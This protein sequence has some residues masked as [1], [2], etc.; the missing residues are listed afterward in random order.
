[1]S[2]FNGTNLGVVANISGNNTFAGSIGF[3][4]AGSG[5]GTGL[6]RVDIFAGSLELDGMLTRYQG[7]GANTVRTIDKR[8]TGDLIIS[9]NN[10]AAIPN[11]SMTT[12]I[13]D[14]QMQVNE[15]RVVLRSQAADPTN[16]GNLPA[17]IDVTVAAGAALVLDNSKGV[18]TN[19]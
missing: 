6:N 4:N 16:T 18:N 12:F 10:L 15:G 3:G 11:A 17:E 2:S 7:T 9:G 5:A 13:P 8:G 14:S 19:R 1:S